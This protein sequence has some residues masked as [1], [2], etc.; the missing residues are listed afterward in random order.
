M[1]ETHRIIQAQ[2]KDDYLLH[3]ATKLSF[4]ISVLAD[5]LIRA[6][7]ASGCMFVSTETFENWKG[8]LEQLDD[9][10]VIGV[11]HNE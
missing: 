10:C 1:T 7:C 4:F 5:S 2:K 3:Q 11:K 6:N 8:S 9:V